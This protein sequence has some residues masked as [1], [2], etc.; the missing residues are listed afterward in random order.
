MRTSHADLSS[1]STGLDFRNIWHSLRCTWQSRLG[2]CHLMDPYAA[3]KDVALFC[4]TV[5]Y[6]L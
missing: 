2:F 3:Q 1:S 5:S 6:S 4:P